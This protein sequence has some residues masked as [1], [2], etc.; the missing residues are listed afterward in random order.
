M[1]SAYQND[2]KRG[3]TARH[4]P[5]DTFQGPV[6]HHSIFNTHML[7]GGRFER[8]RSNP[9]HSRVPKT[10]KPRSDGVLNPLMDSVFFAQSLPTAVHV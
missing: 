7:T 1:T 3:R 6:L 4:T 5:N 9:C 8:L 10:P 2:M